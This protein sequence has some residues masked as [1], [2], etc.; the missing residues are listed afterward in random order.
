MSITTS[1]TKH[2]I[3]VYA[4]TFSVA[5][6]GFS[7]ANVETYQGLNYIDELFNQKKYTVVMDRGYDSNDII[8]FLQNKKN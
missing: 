8:Q 3:P 7:S 2:P 6:E 1:Q 5:E 4:H